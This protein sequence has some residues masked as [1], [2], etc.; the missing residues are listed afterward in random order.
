MSE[1]INLQKGQFLMREH[2]GSSE[3]YFVKSGRLSVL[4]MK[5]GTEREI[6]VIVKGELVG[7]MSF[8]DKK[9]RSASVRAVENCEL[10]KI[11]RE[12]YD[13]FFKELPAWHG[14]LIN[15]LLGRLRQANAKVK[16]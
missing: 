16:I 5:G 11:A 15:T 14:A 2:D 8:L 1:E 13:T 3:M 10:I 9:P 7:E 4:K 6:C 12:S